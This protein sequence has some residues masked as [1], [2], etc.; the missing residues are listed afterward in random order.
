MCGRYTL[1]APDPAA[2]RD[3]FGIS[4]SIEVRQR[5]NVAPGDEVRFT[6]VEEFDRAG[7]E[8]EA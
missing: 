6:A 2:I 5:F 1:T 7:I 4:E 3:R 8:V